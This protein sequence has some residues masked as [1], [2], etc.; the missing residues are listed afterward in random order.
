VSLYRSFLW[1]LLLAALGA[2]AWELLQPD[3]GEVVIR[4]HGTTVT[5]TVAFFLLASILLLFT[6]WLLWSAFRFPYHAWQNYAQKQA[7]SRLNN[8]LT[9]FYE[10]RY[11]RAYRLLL[12]A[13]EDKNVRDLALLGARQAAI[14]QEDWVAAA[15]LLERLNLS[16]P[17]LAASNN[18]RALLKQG[19]AK[20]ALD[21]MMSRPSTEWSPIARGIA[22]EAAVTL[23]QFELARNWLT[24]RDNGLS[25]KQQEQ[26]NALYQQ[27]YLQ[28]ADSADT[29]WQRWHE[30]SAPNKTSTAMAEA[31]ANRALA[32][33]MSGSAAKALIESLETQYDAAVVRALSVLAHNDKS[34][35][36]RMAALV[37]LHPADADL[38][39]TLGAWSK[40]CGN[41]AEAINYWQ[42]AIAQGGGAES[43]NQLG[44]T[45]AEQGQFEQAYIAENNARRVLNGET[46]LPMSG[47]TLQQKIAAEAVSEQRNEHGIP[48]LPQ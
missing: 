13:S 25:T 38:Q 26:L 28:G 34:L 31:F 11:S 6:L 47:I 20:P 42:R 8:G 9:A 17:N 16:N 3:F 23:Q 46:P 40:A 4:W 22:I 41:S 39:H 44:Q 33:G 10:G 14:V 21:V 2:L 12:K 5:T 7:R 48:W 43:W 19:K 24:A 45:F 35:L 29:L 37:P 32:L 30:L 15:Q 18:A 1:W 27:H 36:D